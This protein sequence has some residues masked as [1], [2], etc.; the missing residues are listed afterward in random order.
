M[1][2]GFI[3]TSS[4]E[5]DILSQYVIGAR[6][7]LWHHVV[8]QIRISRYVER[9]S[10]G[11]GRPLQ[12]RTPVPSNAIKNGAWSGLNRIWLPLN[13]HG[14]PCLSECVLCADKGEQAVM[15]V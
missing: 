1:Y 7:I 10:L 9:T 11:L 13:Y 12:M 5:E 2:P 4:K 14:V 6:E 15:H 3:H 8:S